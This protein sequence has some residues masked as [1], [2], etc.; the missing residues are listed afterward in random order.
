LNDEIKQDPMRLRDDLDPL[1]KKTLFPA[2]KQYKT[3]RQ[4]TGPST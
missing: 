4:H 1:H 3:I 2:S